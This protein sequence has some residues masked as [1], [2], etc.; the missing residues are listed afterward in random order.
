MEIIKVS[1]EQHAETIEKLAKEIIPEHYRSFLPML[2][3]NFFIERFQTAT[4][5]ARQLQQG[6][7]YYLVKESDDYAAYMGIEQKNDVLVLSKIYTK[8]KYRGRGIGRQLLDIALQ[9][10][11]E[12]HL[13]VIELYVVKENLQA[14]EFY[15]RNGYKITDTFSIKYDS[16]YTVSEYKMCRELNGLK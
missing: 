16:G 4:A 6:F 12:F 13:P 2:Q 5:I 8:K 7:E 3:I 9:R 14:V 11:V 1:K 15:K 10:A